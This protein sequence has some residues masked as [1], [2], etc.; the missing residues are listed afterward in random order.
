MQVIVRRLP[1]ELLV[2]STAQLTE[3]DPVASLSG[4][5]R[6]RLDPVRAARHGGS[7]HVAVHRN[8]RKIPWRD[9]GYPGS[10]LDQDRISP[11]DA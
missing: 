3:V 5:A 2:G 1:D 9:P 4:A 6:G 10:N 11:I 8:Q 7:Q